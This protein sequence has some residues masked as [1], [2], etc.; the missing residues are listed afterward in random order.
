[1]ER[2]ALWGAAMNAM[3]KAVLNIRYGNTAPIVVRGGS[4]DHM[5]KG[6]SLTLNT[7]IGKVRD[8]L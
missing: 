4:A 5:A 1:M 8:A 7:F 6:G 3:R 2:H